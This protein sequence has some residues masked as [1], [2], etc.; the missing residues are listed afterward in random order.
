ME[1]EIKKA[2]KV[3]SGIDEETAEAVEDA[4]INRMTEG[5]EIPSASELGMS[6]EEFNNVWE[7]IGILTDA[8]AYT[9]IG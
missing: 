8:Y 4:Y 7:A 1:E 6:E 2:R 9:Y 5:K 3:L